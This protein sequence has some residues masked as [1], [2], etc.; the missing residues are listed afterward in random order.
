MDDWTAAQKLYH[1]LYRTRF[2]YSDRGS[3][4]VVVD[5]WHG[6]ADHF[7]FGTESTLRCRFEEVVGWLDSFELLRLGARQAFRR[8]RGGVAGLYHAFFRHDRAHR[9]F[10]AFAWM[11]DGYPVNLPRRLDL[12]RVTVTESTARW[13]RVPSEWKKGA[14]KFGEFGPGGVDLRMLH[15]LGSGGRVMLS[16]R[17]QRTI[18]D[19]LTRADLNCGVRRNT[20]SL[21]Q[22]EVVAASPGEVDAVFGGDPG[23]TLLGEFKRASNRV[24]YRPVIVL[25]LGRLSPGA[26]GSWGRLVLE[27]VHIVFNAESGS[28]HEVG[29]CVAPLDASLKRYP[30]LDRALS[31]W[32]R[33]R[34]LCH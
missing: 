15:P 29:R 6:S 8:C 24:W 23:T 32:W 2:A 14:V 20:S 1:A 31:A 9:D 28:P 3:R 16:V 12:G 5:N 25:R 7:A 13:E 26:G 10:P 27:Y 21:V 17:R 34:V 22:F 11:L 30:L 18:R 19:R 4:E 33:E